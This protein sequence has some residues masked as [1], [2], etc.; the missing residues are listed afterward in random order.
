MSASNLNVTDCSG[1]NLFRAGK[2]PTPQAEN[3]FFVE[4]TGKPVQPRSPPHKQKIHSLWNRP[5]SLFLQNS[6]RC[7]IAH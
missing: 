2:M 6:L 1:S 7:L 4:Q 5:E 3:S